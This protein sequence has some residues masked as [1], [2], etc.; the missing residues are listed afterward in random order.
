[1]DLINDEELLIKSIKNNGLIP[2]R[3]THGNIFT[4]MQKIQRNYDTIT[5]FMVFIEKH[6]TGH[7]FNNGL[8]QPYIF[9]NMVKSVVDYIFIVHN[10]EI[11]LPAHIINFLKDVRRCSAQYVEYHI[12]HPDIFNSLNNKMKE[13]VIILLSFQL[14]IDMTH[15]PLTQLRNTTNNKLDQ[16]TL[17]SQINKMPLFTELPFL[18]QSTREK[19]RSDVASWLVKLTNEDKPLMLLSASEFILLGK[20][21]FEFQ[22]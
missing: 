1:M 16:P 7:Y 9:Y 13:T 17:L 8:S 19:I 15:L 14:L 20:E 5:N 10:V 6:N 18:R 22:P 11:K 21:L 12:S 4:T 3:E 2:W